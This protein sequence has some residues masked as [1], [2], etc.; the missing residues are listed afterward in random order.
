MV[1]FNKFVVVL[2]IAVL[3]GLLLVGLD[4]G[5]LTG[6]H[7]VRAGQV[8]AA[9]QHGEIHAAQPTLV[10]RYL[11]LGGTRTRVLLESEKTPACPFW[12]AD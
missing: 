7:R 8:Y 3:A 4:R 1:D 2:V 12:L 6:Y 5:F 9:P 11:S 10:C